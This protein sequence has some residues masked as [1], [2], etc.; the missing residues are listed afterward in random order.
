MG[1]G[2]C[3]IHPSNATN[4]DLHVNSV[5]QIPWA[6]PPFFIIRD[7]HKSFYR[8]QEIKTLLT[9]ILA[10]TVP[11]TPEWSYK[12]ALIMIMCNLLVLFIGKYAIQKPGAGPAIPA[13]LPLVF[14]GFGL[15]EL[16]AVGSFGHI[17]G[18]GMI[19]GMGNAGL[20]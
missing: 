16:L 13:S 9:A 19:L 7:D 15:P 18:T 1:D 5:E 11:N 8:I 17:L 12:V 6:I 2:D 10:Q 3:L 4:L 20:L 14:E